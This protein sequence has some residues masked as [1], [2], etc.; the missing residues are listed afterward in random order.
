MQTSLFT[1][2]SPLADRLRPQTLEDVI[3]QQHLLG[4]GCPLRAWLERGARRSIVLWGPPGVGKTSLAR[5]AASYS[6]L[7]YRELN[8]GVSGVA[9][10]R[11]YIALG[12]ERGLLLLADEL[13]RWSRSQTETLLEALEKGWI[14]LIGATTE[15]PFVAI[16]RALLSRLQVFEL[17]GLGPQGLKRALQRAI[18]H[19][20]GIHLSLTPEAE[21]VL[22]QSC[23]GDIRRLYTLLEACEELSKSPSPD[24]PNSDD[25]VA[26]QP[27]TIA[28]EMAERVCSSLYVG[29]DDTTYYQ[30]VSAL[31]KSIRGSSPQ[32]AIFYLGRLL[33]AGADPVRVARRIVVTASEDIGLADPQ[34]LGVATAA[35]QAVASLGMPE[36]RY[37]LAE[38]V[39]YL[40]HAPKSNRT[41]T[42]IDRAMEAGRYPHPV[43]NHLSRDRASGYQYPHDYPGGYVEQNYFPTTLRDRLFYQPVRRGWEARYCD[44]T[45]GSP[46]DSAASMEDSG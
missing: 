22:L 34:A 17:R 32:A 7:P 33:V 45:P 46:D 43:P 15:N 11:K 18:A 4:A 41:A 20:N 9:E 25:S 23:G 3:G 29:C 13:H 14:V 16:E 42:A 8:A 28:L 1:P 12:K 2:Q 26:A 24:T 30:L 37:A 44:W 39:L 31:Q 38:A 5:L 19:P 21:Q 6:A 35:S 40:A 10:I 36:C 27:Q